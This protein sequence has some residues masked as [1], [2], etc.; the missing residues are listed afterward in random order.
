MFTEN[1]TLEF[2]INK[3]NHNLF[4]TGIPETEG[5]TFFKADLKEGFNLLLL[6]HGLNNSNIESTNLYPR[7]EKVLLKYIT[8]DEEGILDDTGHI[9]VP[10]PNAGFVPKMERNFPIVI[11]N[12]VFRLSVEGIIDQPVEVYIK[13][14]GE[15]NLENTNG[16]VLVDAYK[17]VTNPADSIKI[18]A[19]GF[20]LKAHSF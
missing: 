3:D 16:S 11:L 10:F 12:A 2:K 14:A 4:V 15:I 20:T 1:N 13:A 8:F 9:V 19:V 7:I 6:S 17:A 18:S 5:E